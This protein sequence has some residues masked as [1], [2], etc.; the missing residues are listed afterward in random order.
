V[1]EDT[2]IL[3]G[4]LADRDRWTATRCSID[5]ALHVVSTRTAMLMLRE[6]Y[7]GTRRFEDFVNRV[8]VTEAV[9][10]ARLRELTNAG[11]LRR[12]PYREPGQ[13]TRHEYRLTQQGLDLFPALLALAGW[14]DK[15][16]AG[17]AGPPL[18]FRHAGCGAPVAAVVRCAAGHDVPVYEL[19]VRGA[20]KRRGH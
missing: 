5:A 17:A 9:A 19:A 15:Y 8:G 3:E 10:A 16:L 11:L 1:D 13:R 12:E 18:L 6:A 14:G 4:A 7:Y 20:G 2:V